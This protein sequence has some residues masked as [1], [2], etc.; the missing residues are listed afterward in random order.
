MAKALTT[1][2]FIQKAKVVHGEKYDYSQVEYATKNIPVVII[3][4][5]HGPFKTKP[6]TH[7]KSG[8]VDCWKE[9]RKKSSGPNTVT[10]E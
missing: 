1:E 9:S 6:S 7:M 5:K 8:C 3:C 2:E 4:P 10:V